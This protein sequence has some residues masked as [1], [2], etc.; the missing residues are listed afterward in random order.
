MLGRYVPLDDNAVTEARARDVFSVGI[1][2]IGT[3]SSVTQLG[4][5][6]V[7]HPGPLL[8]DVLALPVRL[9]PHGSGVAV[10][11]ALIHIAALVTLA[12]CSR[13]LLGN[14]GACV[15]MAVAAGF[16]W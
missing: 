7:N 14:A 9:F 12:W 15:V 13:R 10:G 5:D 2:L 1:P 6:V 3:V 8:F 4:P 11:V 16:L